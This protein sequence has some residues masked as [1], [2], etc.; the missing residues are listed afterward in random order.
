MFHV[1]HLKYLKKRFEIFLDTDIFLDVLSGE[2]LFKNST[3]KKCK[4]VFEACYTSVINA[5]EVFAEYPVNKAKRIFKDIG[6][7]GIPFRY[8]ITTGNIM[9]VVKK[10]EP[11]TVLGTF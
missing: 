1:S 11:E 9:R 6:I 2:T 3:L 8:S 10:K 7:L 5:S 4:D